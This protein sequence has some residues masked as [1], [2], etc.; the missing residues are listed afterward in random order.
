MKR[1]L[2]TRIGWK[3]KPIPSPVDTMCVVPQTVAVSGMSADPV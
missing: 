3:R 1:G 2:K